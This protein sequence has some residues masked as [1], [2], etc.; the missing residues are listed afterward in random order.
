MQVLSWSPN[1]LLLAGGKS[2]PLGIEA[3]LERCDYNLGRRGRAVEQVSLPSPLSAG[4][5]GFLIVLA[6]QHLAAW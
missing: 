2:G 6:R 5:K 4:F 3:G 1:G